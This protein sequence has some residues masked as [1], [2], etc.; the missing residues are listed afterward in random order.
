MPKRLRLST[1][2]EYLY[3]EFGII[4]VDD[5]EKFS[6]RELILYIQKA[7]DVLEDENNDQK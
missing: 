2:L 3:D 1:I 4:Y 7:Y 6:Y 5:I